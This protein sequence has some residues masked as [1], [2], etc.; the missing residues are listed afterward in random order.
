MVGIRGGPETTLT[1]FEP[2]RAE[3]TRLAVWHLNHSVTT[4]LM[5]AL[6]LHCAK[7]QIQHRADVNCWDRT[8]VLSNFTRALSL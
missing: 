8:S 2:A 6:R 7:H 4:S 3:P 5:G 1:G